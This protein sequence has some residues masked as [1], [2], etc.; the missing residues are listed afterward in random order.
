MVGSVVDG[1]NWGSLEHLVWF[2]WVYAKFVQCYW[3]RGRECD[4]SI[5]ML[6]MN[7]IYVKLRDDLDRSF[8]V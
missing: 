3:G 1:S 4:H 7:K 5:F 6:W 8:W 2:E